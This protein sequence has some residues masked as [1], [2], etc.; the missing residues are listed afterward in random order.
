MTEIRIPGMAIRNRYVGL[1]QS[2]STGIRVIEVESLNAPDNL[3][4]S[5]FVTQGAWNAGL[6]WERA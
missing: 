5:D 1:V 3:Q 2:C 4:V 6:Q